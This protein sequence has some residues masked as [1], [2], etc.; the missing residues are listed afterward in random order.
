MLNEGQL[1]HLSATL[2][3]AEERLLDL[4]RR[5][6]DG[7]VGQLLTIDN[8]LSAAERAIVSEKIA[9]LLRQI[10]DAGARLALTPGWQSLRRALVGTLSVMWA[11]LQ[12]AKSGSLSAYGETDPRLPAMLD[13]LIERI[14]EGLL[15]LCQVLSRG[16]C[17][18]TRE[19]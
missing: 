5:L 18:G 10:A 2:R 1:R 11:D 12:D 4:Q 19:L 14:A 8:D 13:P 6:N 7:R 3:L 9:A 15:E 16:E 17:R